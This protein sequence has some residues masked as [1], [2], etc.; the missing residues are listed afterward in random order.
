MFTD[1]KPDSQEHQLEK[2]HTNKKKPNKTKQKL[3]INKNQNSKLNNGKAK[4]AILISNE[5]VYRMSN[6]F[7]GKDIHFIM[8]NRPTIQDAITII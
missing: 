8:I 5:N 3:K 1:T 6:I 2:Y 4:V 7:R